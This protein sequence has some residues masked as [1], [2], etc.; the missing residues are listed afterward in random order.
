M[1]THVRCTSYIKGPG[2]LVIQDASLE[3][4]IGRVVRET[5]RENLDFGVFFTQT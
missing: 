1:T 5:V 4:P 3:E 2:A